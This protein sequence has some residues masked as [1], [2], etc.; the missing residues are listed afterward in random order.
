[1]LY[2]QDGIQSNH[3]NQ[4]STS[5]LFI[6]LDSSTS[7]CKAIAWSL[8]GEMVSM[9]RAAHHLS[10]PHTGWHE[11]DADEWWLAVCQALKECL[12]G[13]Q[14]AAV[15]GLSL[16]VQRETFVTIDA[17][18]HPLRPAVLWMDTRAGEQ[19][20]VLLEDLPDFQKLTGKRLSVNLIPPKYCWLQ[21]HE[22]EL[23]EQ[24]SQIW[25]VH[26]YLTAQLIGTAITSW[27]AAGPTGILNL[28][29]MQYAQP[30]LDAIGLNK[31]NLPQLAAPGEMIGKITQKAAEQTGLL[32]GTPV[33]AGIGDGQACGSGAGINTTGSSY[34]TLGTSV[35]SGTYAPQF[36]IDDAF[37]TM[38]G[39]TPGTFLLETVLLSGTYTLDWYLHTLLQNTNSL[40]KL[41]EQA[42]QLP[43]GAERLVLLPYWNS[44]L[45]PYWDAD[46]RGAIIGWRGIHT[47][48]HVFRAILEGI[49]FEQRLHTEGVVDAINTPIQR[50]IVMG[51]GSSNDLWCQII[52]DVT[53]RNVLRCAQTEAASLGAAMLAAVGNGCYP[54]LITASSSMTSTKG[55]VFIPV[56]DQ[57][58]L[59]EHLYQQVY[60]SLYPSLK[61]LMG[62]L[63]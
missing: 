63:K 21:E 1:M 54:D 22:P 60:L 23:L 53:G 13:I 31:E 48:A 35:I 45:N 5:P 2:P 50:Y 58:E 47:Q 12:K 10:Q 9:G 56:P 30:V 26:A 36:L 52:A 4:Q 40:E 51:G 55:K 19:V 6:G 17:Q 29:T 62:E 15:K 59:Y 37:R 33:Y 27:G 18:G 25:D 20:E 41:T 8:N 44:A 61:D 24:V 14:P 57:Q 38:V 7:A 34:L 46:A 28:N 49:A 32:A 43:P 39:G 16:S 11:Q 3:M 42:K